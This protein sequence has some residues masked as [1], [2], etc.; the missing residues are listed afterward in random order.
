MKKEG[1][2]KTVIVAGMLSFALTAPVLTPVASFVPGVTEITT[3][4]EAKSLTVKAGKNKIK[5]K[6]KA[7]KKWKKSYRL[8]YIETSDGCH[9]YYIVSC[10]SCCGCTPVGVAQV[11]KKTGKI[12]YWFD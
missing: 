5:K 12:D 4:S 9:Y 2:I 8:D 11:N 6:L 7:K 3:Q 10:S 1:K